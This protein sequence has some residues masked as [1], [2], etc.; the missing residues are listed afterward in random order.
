MLDIKISKLEYCS[1]FFYYGNQRSEFLRKIEKELQNKNQTQFTVNKSKEIYDLKSIAKLFNFWE[2]DFNTFQKEETQRKKNEFE[3]ELKF[4]Y[5]NF[6]KLEK[7]S[8]SVPKG[9]LQ[10]LYSFFGNP[11]DFLKGKLAK[12]GYALTSIEEKEPF[13]FNDK[14][15]LSNGKEVSL[16]SVARTAKKDEM[17]IGYLDFNLEEVK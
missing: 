4:A 2:E 10:D 11:E 13:G 8:L 7:V 16:F 3:K 9:Q 1:L 17:H 14:M 5:D 15:M 12:L 6:D